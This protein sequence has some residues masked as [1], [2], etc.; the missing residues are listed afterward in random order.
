MFRGDQEEKHNCWNH[1]MTNLRSSVPE[2]TELEFLKK[3]SILP[4]CPGICS[5]SERALKGLEGWTNNNSIVSAT[6]ASFCE[7]KSSVDSLIKA[8]PVSR[9]H[10]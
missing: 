10:R 6:L 5:F 7:N 1:S 3:Q 4:E 2:T 9:I 8:T